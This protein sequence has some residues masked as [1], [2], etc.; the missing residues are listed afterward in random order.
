MTTPVH[1]TPE[2]TNSVPLRVAVCAN[3]VAEPL[4]EPLQ[5]WLNKMGI[6]NS[7]AFAPY[8]QIH[9]QLL[10]PSSLLAQNRNGVNVI[11]L[12]LEDWCRDQAPGK[13]DESG[14]ETQLQRNV[15]DLLAGIAALRKR[16]GAPLVVVVCPNSPSIS[17]AL[18]KSD[19]FFIVEEVMRAELSGVSS[20][21]FVPSKVWSSLYP[22]PTYHDE[23]ADAIAHIPYT[24]LLY[25]AVAMMIVRK[26]HK[27]KF[28]RRKVI[29]LD[30]DNTLWN[31]VVG[32]DGPGGISIDAPRRALQE[33][34]L[35]QQ[36]RGMLVVLCS[37]NNEQDV[38]E[39]FDQRNDMLVKRQHIVTSRINWNSKA[40][41]LISISKELELGLDS[42]VFL[43]DDPM[44][45]AEVRAHVP[46]VLTL[47]LP[48]T[49]SDIPAFLQH[50]WVFDHDETTNEDRQRTQLYHEH[51]MRER[52]RR[53]SPT[54]AE[55]VASL[56]LS[57]DISSIEKQYLHRVSELTF[58]TN[59]FNTTGIKR[60]ASEIERLLGSQ[61]LEGLVVRVMDRFGDYGLVGV[62]F[63]Q[64][65]ADS[66][67]VENIL[68]SCRTLGRG[69]EHRLVAYL[70]AV[71]RGRN[72]ATVKLACVPSS[73][74][75]PATNFLESLPA[76]RRQSVDGRRIFELSAE[77]AAAITYAPSAA[78]TD[79]DSPDGERV[80]AS[81]AGKE[82]S[83]IV[84]LN[85]FLASV[86][87]SLRD[88][89]SIHDRF[90]RARVRHSSGA[91]AATP[92]TP[93]EAAIAAIF[94]DLLGLEAVDLHQ[95]FFDLGGHSLIAMQVLARVNEEFNVELTP[96]LLFTSK[97][98]VV[99]LAAAVLKEQLKRLDDGEVE[100]IFQ[101][102]A[103]L[104]T[105][106]GEKADKGDLAEN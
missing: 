23:R 27:L 97:F 53:E 14:R 48:T 86:A 8:D 64:F 87:E 19:A 51:F 5:H 79:N 33:L 94:C 56:N 93:M 45:C 3:F 61:Q 72:L 2:L 76:K 63:Y 34:V 13:I 103:Q 62:I 25:S 15:R 37:R 71:A 35:E 50:V 22:S 30:C 32:E 44:S 88:V 9:Q 105:D 42:F 52:V 96:M 100:S 80:A 104:T 84:S 10:D 102:L 90:T 6:A 67:L 99:D 4:A 73:K 60:T 11:L 89:D 29:A 38:W 106:P 49:T 18:P 81:P 98:A 40:E 77:K 82:R 36:S 78:A 28:P 46:E 70:G 57:I 21:E 92:S 91:V 26:F 47:C 69:V 31:G 75:L 68:L 54:L 58:R 17:A 24:P 95:G 59:Q 55:F 74:N 66:L 41:N 101:E 12:R 43:D 20:M 16:H 39:V 85:G 83:D 1:D 65:E 7:V